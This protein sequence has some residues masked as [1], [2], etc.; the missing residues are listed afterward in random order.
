VE[1]I[2]VVQASVEPAVTASQSNAQM[3]NANLRLSLAPT[4]KIA[5]VLRGMFAPKVE[6]QVIGSGA[7]NVSAEMGTVIE[8]KVQKTVALIAAVQ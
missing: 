5:P 8:G 6:P 4:A 7:M 2:S 1:I 3:E